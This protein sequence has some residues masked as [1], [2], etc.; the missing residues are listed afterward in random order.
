MPPFLQVRFFE[1]LL[2]ELPNDYI[3][4]GLFDLKHLILQIS[5]LLHQLLLFA[6]QLLRLVLVLINLGRPKHLLGEHIP[7]LPTIRGLVLICEEHV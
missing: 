2:L 6:H 3:D 4:L 7:L 1:K 5:S